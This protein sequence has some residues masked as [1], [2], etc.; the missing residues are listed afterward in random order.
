VAH[1]ITLYLRI[2]LAGAVLQHSAVHSGFAFNAIEMPLQASLLM[3]LR[4]AGLVIPLAWMGSRLAGI[5][6]I[7]AGMAAGQMISGVVALFWFGRVLKQKRKAG[8]S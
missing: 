5:P 2:I 1:L 6:G 7:F 3:A 8:L 4:L